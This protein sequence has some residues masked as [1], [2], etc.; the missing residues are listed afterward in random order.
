MIKDANI[1]IFALIHLMCGLYT[2]TSE[3]FRKLRGL[4]C[5]KDEQGV[6]TDASLIRQVQSNTTF[7]TS[8]KKVHNTD[9]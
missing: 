8:Q 3:I 2:K 1:S 6:G 7:F 9:L 5:N 4:V